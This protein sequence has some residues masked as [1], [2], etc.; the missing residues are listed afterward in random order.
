MY[1]EKERSDMAYMIFSGDQISTTGG[2]ADF[3]GRYRSLST[4]IKRAKELAG[5]S[6]EAWAEVVDLD[7]LM[8]VFASKGDVS[9]ALNERIAGMIYDE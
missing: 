3:Q 7:S 2:M 4:A 9:S 5:F 1:N 6:P 8:V